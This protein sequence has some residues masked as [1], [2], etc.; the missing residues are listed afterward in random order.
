MFFF[1][2]LSKKIEIIFWITFLLE[3]NIIRF[4]KKKIKQITFMWKEFCKN[5]NIQHLPEIYI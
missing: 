4:E 5:V 1:P 2:S 3:W